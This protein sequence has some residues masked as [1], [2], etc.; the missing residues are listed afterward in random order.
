MIIFMMIGFWVHALAVTPVASQ[1]VVLHL[2][3]QNTYCT[4]KRGALAWWKKGI[5]Q[6]NMDD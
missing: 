3:G 1:T 2:T 5:W 6:K 4:M